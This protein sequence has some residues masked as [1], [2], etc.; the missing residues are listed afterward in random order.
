MTPRWLRRYRKEI[1][2]TLLFLVFDLRAS[3]QLEERDV[4]NV[5]RRLPEKEPA[6]EQLLLEIRYALNIRDSLAEILGDDGLSD[7]VI[8]ELLATVEVE[9]AARLTGEPR[10]RLPFEPGGFRSLPAPLSSE[11]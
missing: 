6:L 8:R 10:R 9:I 1:E 4:A 2:H 5:L 11:R 3:E 7:R